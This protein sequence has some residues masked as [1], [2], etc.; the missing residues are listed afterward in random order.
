MAARKNKGVG[1]G[2]MPEGWKKKIQ[3][4]MIA[5]RLFDCFEGKVVM[6]PVALKAGL[7]IFNKLEPDLAR[8]EHTGKNGGAIEVV[9]KVVYHGID[10]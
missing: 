2:S 3:A 6:D 9:G 4:S 1:K 10:E 8:Q 7:A 5:N